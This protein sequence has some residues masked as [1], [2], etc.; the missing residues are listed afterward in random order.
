M[1]GRVSFSLRG[2]RMPWSSGLLR[3]T[4]RAKGRNLRYGNGDDVP[5]SP[6]IHSLARIVM[7]AHPHMRWKWITRITH[8]SLLESEMHMT[9]NEGVE[10][11]SQVYE[12][13][14]VTAKPENLP[15]VKQLEASENDL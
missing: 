12:R 9:L 7:Y 2:V 13:E 6:L 1:N 4:N 14:A 11:R 8:Y 10:A 3:C 15:V 5:S